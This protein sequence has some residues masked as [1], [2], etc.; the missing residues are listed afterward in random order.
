MHCSCF[1]DCPGREG[2]PGTGEDPTCGEAPALATT[3]TVSTAPRRRLLALEKF[4]SIHSLLG[5]GTL[6]MCISQ[7]G[8]Q[9]HAGT[10]RTPNS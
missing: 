2:G 10:D 8:R 5:T 6:H 4:S 9:R 7:A 1:E 3:N